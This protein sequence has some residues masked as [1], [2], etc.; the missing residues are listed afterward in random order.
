MKEFKSEKPAYILIGT[1]ED[2]PK[3]FVQ[4][5]SKEEARKFQNENK[6][7][8]ECSDMIFGKRINGHARRAESIEEMEI[9]DILLLDSM[10]T[11]Y[12]IRIS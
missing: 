11:H 2:Y 7:D 10:E 1:L 4:I 6:S 5:F 9:G 8:F 12:F 3:G